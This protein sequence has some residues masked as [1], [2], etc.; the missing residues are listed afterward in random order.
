MTHNGALSLLIP[1][2]TPRA[3]MRQMSSLRQAGPESAQSA[4]MVLEDVNMIVQL[5]M[6]PHSQAIVNSI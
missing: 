2:R 5:E 1:A 3:C 4:G 6:K